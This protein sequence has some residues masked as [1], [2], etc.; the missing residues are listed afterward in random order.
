MR[1]NTPAYDRYST[2]HA[3]DLLGS[4]TVIDVRTPGEYASGHLPGA[5]NIPLDQV[6]R[7]VPEIAGAA[8]RGEVLIVCASGARS[9]SA[10]ELLAGHGVRAA[11]LSGGTRAWAERGYALERPGDGTAPGACAVPRGSW[12][13]ERQVRLA[14]G[15][16]VLL[17]T[18][19]GA[20]L[21]PAW[22]L[23]S[24]GIAGGLVFSALTDTCGM[25]AVLAKLPHNRPA[26]ADLEAAL[27]R[28]RAGGR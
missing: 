28:L 22:L 23:L 21:H 11:S 16:L 12:A 8:G 20:V 5:V 24:G 3:R 9:G 7:A 10:C 14:A 18:V 27:E 25:A 2:E 6:R 1:R 4:L 26:R 19:L 17:G 15:V 13:M